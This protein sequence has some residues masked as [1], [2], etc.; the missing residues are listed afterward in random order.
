MRAP[1]KRNYHLVQAHVISG[2][3]ADVA[4]K[5]NVRSFPMLVF[6]N[7]KGEVLCRTRGF[8]DADIA[9]IKSPVGLNIGAETPAEIAVAILGEVIAA[10]R[11]GKA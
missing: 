10:F 1:Y 8:K 4:K 9:R 6:F 2:P 5:Y 7:A 3:G 11:G